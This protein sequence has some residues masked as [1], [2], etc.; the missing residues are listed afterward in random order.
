[1]ILASSKKGS[2]NIISKGPG[3]CLYNFIFH[4]TSLCFVYIIWRNILYALLTIITESL[5]HL[6]PPSDGLSL[7][8]LRPVGVDVELVEAHQRQLVPDCLKVTE[9]QFP[10]EQNDVT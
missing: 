4:F 3:C 6:E 9:W 5:V 7:V 8:D 2:I 1:M 10:I